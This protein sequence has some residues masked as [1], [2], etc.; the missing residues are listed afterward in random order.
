[1]AVQSGNNA[2][3]KA[4]RRRHTVEEFLTLVDDIRKIRSDAEFGTDAIVGFSGETKEQF[5][6]TVELFKKVRFSVAF[7]SMYSER[8]GTRSQKNLKDNVSLEEKKWRHGCLTKVWKKY[9]P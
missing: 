4:M 3:L 6:D 2:V 9:K 8:E 7:I 1:I 5:M